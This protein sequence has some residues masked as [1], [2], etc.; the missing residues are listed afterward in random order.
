LLGTAGP[1]LSVVTATGATVRS[2]ACMP[3][4]LSTPRQICRA[5]A[6]VLPWRE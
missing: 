6:A 3:L 1:G 2:R 4:T 5:K